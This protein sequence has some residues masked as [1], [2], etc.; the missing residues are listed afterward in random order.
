MFDSPPVVVSAIAVVIAA[1]VLFDRLFSRSLSREEHKEYKLGLDKQFG[2]WQRRIE[3]DF[4]KV[5]ADIKTLEHTR[6]TGGELEMATN[7]IVARVVLLESLI[8]EV[9]L[10][11]AASNGRPNPN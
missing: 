7:A 5:E 6:P 10:K 4:D 3:R 2:D 8:K 9:V 1:I 11:S